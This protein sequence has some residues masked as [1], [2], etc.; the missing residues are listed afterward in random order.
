MAYVI[1]MKVNGGIWEDVEEYGEDDYPLALQALSEYNTCRPSG[2]S[3][4]WIVRCNDSDER[5]N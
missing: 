5:R 1:Q 3:F 4:R 2:T